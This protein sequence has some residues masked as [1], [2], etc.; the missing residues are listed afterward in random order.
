MP[1]KTNIEFEKRYRTALRQ[2]L[3][4]GRSIGSMQLLGRLAGSSGLDVLALAR[5][6]DK[7]LQELNINRLLAESPDDEFLLTQSNAFFHEV[8]APIEKKHESMKASVANA[9][10]IGGKLMRCND[11]LAH[12]RRREHKALAQCSALEKQLERRIKL[13]EELLVQSRQQQ[14]QSRRLT[15]L[16]LL[17]Q[18]EDRKGISRELHDEVLQILAGVNVQLATLKA[19]A[20]L[21][22]DGLGKRIAQTQRMVGKSIRI[23]HRYARTLRPSM[24]DDLGLIPALRS[25]IRDLPGRKELEINFTTFS[26]VESLSNVQR[27]VLYRVAQEAVTNIVRHA[28][29]HHATVIISKAGNTVCLTVQ[30]DGKAFCVDRVL[31]SKTRK[32]LGLIGMRERIEMVGGKFS[33]QS[34]ADNGTVIRAEIPLNSRKRGAAV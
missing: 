1:N 23:V 29:A 4:K 20:S 22:N 19:A 18:E 30:D 14:A 21:D 25:Y 15:R 5:L 2:H 3:G 7:A 24:L 26:E 12:T 32:G 34:E 8:L 10:G 17:K 33:I 13:H 28:R 31:A 11:E 9:K 16:L 27:T 6:H